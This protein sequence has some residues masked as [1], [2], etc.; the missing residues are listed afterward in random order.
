[1]TLESAPGPFP[2]SDAR[3][4]R[5]DD[6]RQPSWHT[7][8]M[9]VCIDVE[10]A[11]LIPAELADLARRHGEFHANWGNARYWVTQAEQAVQ[12]ATEQDRDAR[13]QALVAGHPLPALTLPGARAEL[14]QATAAVEQWRDATFHAEQAARSLVAQHAAAMAAAA[15]AA[16]LAADAEVLAA[17]E[18]ITEA[19]RRRRRVGRV[20]AL[21]D[22]RW[23]PDHADPGLPQDLAD[24][25]DRI[26]D[27]TQPPVEQAPAEW[28]L[29]LDESTASHEMT[30]VAFDVPDP[31]ALDDEDAEEPPPPP[32]PA[33]LVTDSGPAPRRP[34]A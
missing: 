7:G 33:A 10:L 26:R 15:E 34:R 22:G 11:E 16:S 27:A 24:A 13:A 23:T 32:V 12:V 5:P 29:D 20:F 6:Q 21:T 1:M 14:E 25:L 31:P 2:L 28:F 18:Q 8:E 4:E 30:F 9:N 3:W 19:W 17:V